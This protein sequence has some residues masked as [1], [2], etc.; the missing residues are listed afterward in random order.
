VW[1]SDSDCEIVSNACH[2]TALCTD[3]RRQVAVNQI[4]C[5]V[6]YDVPPPERCGCVQGTCRA[7]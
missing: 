5:S 7:R 6:E 1:V 2:A 4:G 3:R